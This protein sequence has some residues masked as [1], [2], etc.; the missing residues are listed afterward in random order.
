M[1]IVVIGAYGYTGKLICRELTE[2]NLGFSIAGRDQDKLDDLQKEFA[3]VEHRVC[4]D[5]RIEEVHS[6]VANYDLFINCAGPFTEESLKLLEEIAGKGKIYIDISGELGFIRSSKERLD[7]RAID[8]GSLILHGVAFESLITDLMCKKID[9]E[10]PIKQLRVYYKFNQKR[11]SPGTRITMKLSKFRRPIHV[12]NAKWDTI[13]FSKEQHTVEIGAETEFSA[14]PYPLPEIA[15][16]KWNYGAEL[17][18]TYLLLEREEAKFVSPA[19]RPEEELIPTL[20]RLRKLKKPGPSMD[21]CREHISEIFIN[22]NESADN[23]WSLHMRD[24]YSITANCVG[25]MVSELL[26]GSF[27]TGVRSPSEIIRKEPS[28]A[29]ESMGVSIK[30]ERIQTSYAK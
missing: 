30:K 12:E 11:T 4:V 19:L 13:N 6:L 7:Q 20:D 24:M 25:M 23:T 2:R 15:F 17:A 9:K 5:I 26:N 18:K 16:S 22:T 3:G 29:L 8:S 14:I 21:E 10:S 27:V 28:L 1:K